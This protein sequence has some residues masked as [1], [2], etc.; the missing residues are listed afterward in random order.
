MHISY[1][2]ATLLS[3]AL[4]QTTRAHTTFT[5]FFV[6]GVDQGNG[7]CVR[8]SNVM[9]Q[10]TFPLA[11]II[12]DDMACGTFNLVLSLWLLITLV[13]SISNYAYSAQASMVK[14]E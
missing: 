12:S 11:S 13:F 4:S 10:Q 3:L 9:G 14:L 7:T 6:D 8:M 5:N 1:Y 2:K